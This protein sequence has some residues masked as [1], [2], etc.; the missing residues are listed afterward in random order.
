[1]PPSVT[2][3]LAPS[4]TEA[5]CVLIHAQVGF[6]AAEPGRDR[7]H[8]TEGFLEGVLIGDVDSLAVLETPA[9]SRRHVLLNHRRGEYVEQILTGIERQTGVVVSGAQRQ[10]RA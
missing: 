2:S 8:S 4:K 1:L 5:D 10:L 6:A 9:C 7:V 3:L